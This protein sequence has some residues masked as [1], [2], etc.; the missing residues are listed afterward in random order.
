MIIINGLVSDGTSVEVETILAAIEGIYDSSSVVANVDGNILE[1]LEGLSND[2]NWDLPYYLRQ[3]EDISPSPDVYASFFVNILSSNGTALPLGDININDINIRLE[4]SVSG[5]AYSTA[6]I[7]QPTIGKTAGQ[8]YTNFAFQTAEGWDDACV[9]RLTLSSVKA[10]VGLVEYTLQ[11]F[12]WNNVISVTKSI[13]TEVDAITVKLA[14]PSIDTSDNNTIAEVVGNKNDTIA[15]TS[16]IA[17]IKQALA[18]LTNI[19]LELDSIDT[20]IDII[21]SYIDTEITAIKTETD[22]IPATIVKVD[23]IKVETDKI[24]A[25][26]IKID[27]EVVKTSAIK[28]ETDKIPATIVKV[29]AIKVETDKTPATIVKIDAIKTETD[30]IPATI[31]KIDNIKTETDQIGTIT[32][33]GGT[34]T[35]AQVL[36]DANNVSV[37]SRLGTIASYIDTEISAIKVETDQIGTVVNTGG[38]ATLAAVLGNPSAN[39]ISNRL[40][41]IDSTVNAILAIVANIANLVNR[42]F[43]VTAPFDANEIITFTTGSGNSGGTSTATGGTMVLPSSGAAMLADNTCR[44]FLNGVLQVKQTDFVWDSTTT[45]HFTFALDVADWF[46]IERSIPI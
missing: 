15:G 35:I 45:G 8:V 31:T 9:Y 36:G 5:G 20:K 16:A 39:S 17:R 6:G 29:D 44:I 22:K 11:T 18:T 34:A 27:G 37:I 2:V 14:K 33:T 13:D 25:T 26:I 23:A 4:K 41:T 21:A 43:V 40:A 3:S 46:S 24:P 42:N 12:I 38:T 10:T 1:R 28:V 30:K 7:T 32:N 19:G